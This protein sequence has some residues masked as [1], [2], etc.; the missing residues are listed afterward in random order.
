MPVPLNY[1]YYNQKRKRI[2]DTSQ[3]SPRRNRIA[4]IWRKLPLP[5][6]NALGP[7]IRRY[8]S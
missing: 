3:S 5:L 1:Q 4:K 7:F 2:V 8:Y 6:T